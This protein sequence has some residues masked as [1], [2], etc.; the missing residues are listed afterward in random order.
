MQTALTVF[1][2]I[3]AVGIGLAVCVV[4]IGWATY[5]VIR[6]WTTE[7]LKLPKAVDLACAEADLQQAAR[8]LAE[9]KKTTNR[10]VQ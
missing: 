4:A 7:M 3:V 1:L 2:V 5:F 8:E 10:M 6:K 9:E